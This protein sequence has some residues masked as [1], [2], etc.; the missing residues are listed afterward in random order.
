M[1][2]QKIMTLAAMTVFAFASAT[3]RQA[4]ASAKPNS[5]MDKVLA[6]LASKKGKPIESLSAEEARKQPSPADAVSSLI[7]QKG[8][9][10]RTESFAKVLDIKV[11]GAVGSIPARLYVPDSKGPLPVVAYFHGGGFVIADL[12][13]YD[14]SA[15][16]IALGAKAIVVSVAYRLA[17]EN[18]FPAAHDDAFAAYK[19]IVGHAKEMGGDPNKVAVAGESAGGNLAINVSIKARDEGFAMPV[20]QLLVYPVAGNDMNTA[21]YKENADAKPLNKPMM[22]WFVKNYLTSMDQA[23]DTRINV[24]AANLKG[25]PPTTIITA[26]I[27]PLRSEGEDLAKKLKEAGV[28]VSSKNYKGVTH[29]FFGMAPVVGEA[30]NAQKFATSGLKKY[31]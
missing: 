26:Q 12:N 30:K 10:V 7:T 28:K 6:Q 31:F 29:E 14:A 13:T 2:F 16:A 1:R 19:W 4:S 27:D 5:D 20:S 18:K 25:L 17:P 23:K 24:L 9:P 11:D 3:A 8:K 21:S 15:R 22:E